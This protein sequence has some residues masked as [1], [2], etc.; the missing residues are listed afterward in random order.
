MDT[1]AL[2]IRK[3]GEHKKPEYTSINPFQKVPCLK[4]GDFIVRESIS[5]AKYIASKYKTADHWYPKDLQR[6]TRVDEYLDWQHMN[7]RT[8]GNKAFYTKVL[9]PWFTSKP[10]D[11]QQLQV[12]LEA[13]AVCYRQIE[14]NFL[15]DSSFLC[16]EEISL[17]DIF[18]ACEIV[19]T[20]VCGD[21]LGQHPKLQSWIHRVQ[22][23]LSPYFDEIHKPL[24]NSYKE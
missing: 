23:K 12:D 15:G 22:Q 6:R 17:A 20:T 5:A 7:T 18:A 2:W 16:G 9:A 4:D 14:N 3:M 19:Q 21:T 11:T 24:L 13:V 8:I 1:E 10:V